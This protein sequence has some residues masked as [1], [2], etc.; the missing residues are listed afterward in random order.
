MERGREVG[1]IDSQGDIR[2]IA[3]SPDGR[4][5]AA[6]TF[7]PTVRIWDVSTRQL[8]Q[9]LVAE[10]YVTYLGFGP[11]GRRLITA[12][13]S[14]VDLW[15]TVTG[16]RL[17]RLGD[18]DL[19]KD[20]LHDIAFSPDGR[21][22]ATADGRAKTSR[23]W[24]APELSKAGPVAGDPGGWRPLFNGRDLSGWKVYPSGTGQWNVK[25]GILVGSGP[26]SSLFS[27]GGNFQDFHLRAEVRVADGDISGIVF[28]APF[29]SGDIKGY[30]ARINGNGPDPQRTGS[31]YDLSPFKEDMVA[32][33]AWFV[34]EVIAEGSHIVIKVDGKTTADYVDK[35]RRYTAGRIALQH[36]S[37]SVV[38]FRKVEVKER[39]AAETTLSPPA[40]PAE[41]RVPVERNSAEQDLAS[42]GLP[43]LYVPKEDW[44]TLFNGRDTSGWVEDTRR[45][46][47]WDVENGALVGRA[48]TG[49]PGLSY[50][51]SRRDYTD[52]SLRFEF[53]VPQYTNSGFVL[54][55]VPG[56]EPYHVEVSLK[57]YPDGR[58]PSGSLGW[59]PLTFSY[60][61]PVPVLNPSGTWNRMEVEMRGD[62]LSVSING[63]RAT[64]W[65]L[66]KFAA[67]P[68]GLPGLKHRSGRIGFQSVTGVASF[69]N[70]EIRDLQAV[71]GP[72]DSTVR[73]AP[74]GSPRT[75]LGRGVALPKSLKNAIG[76]EL[77]HIPA[78]AF[79]MGSNEEEDSKP[80]HRVRIT[81]PFYLASHEVTQGQFARLFGKN[82]SQFQSNDRLPVES[83]TWLDSIR[84]CNLLSRADRLAPYYEIAGDVVSMKGGPG[85]RL[86]T[87]AEWEY[88]CGEGKASLFCFGD[89]YPELDRYGWHSGNSSLVTHPVGQKLPNA[90]GLYDMHGN[91]W[92]W[93]WD[94]Y[95]EKFFRRT[96]MDDPSWPGPGD[97]HVVRGGSY[98]AG[99]SSLRTANRSAGS[100]RNHPNPYLVGFRVARDGGSTT[101]DSGSP[102]AGAGRQGTPT[103]PAPDVASMGY[104][105]LIALAERTLK[106]EHPDRAIKVLDGCPPD[107]RSWEWAY[108]RRLASAPAGQAKGPLTLKHRGEDRDDGLPYHPKGVWGL[109]FSPDGKVLASNG[110]LVVSLWNAANGRQLAALRGRTR[111]GF[112]VAFSPDGSAVAA[113]SEDGVLKVWDN[114]S[115]HLT[116]VIEPK[117]GPVDG[118]AFSADGARLYTSGTDGTIRVWNAA[119]AAPIAS[120]RG[121][122][123]FIQC[124]SL[125]RDGRLLATGGLHDKTVKVWDA[126]TGQLVSS[127]QNDD[128]I[129]DVA[130][131]PDGGLV[132]AAAWNGT[133]KVIDTSTGLELRAIRGLKGRVWAVAFS[134]D[135]L[136]IASGS[137][138]EPGVVLWDRGSGERIFQLKTST[139]VSDVVFSLD[140]RRLAATGSDGVIQ[141]WDASPA[142]EASPKPAGSAR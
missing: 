50:L 114:S 135:G 37:G 80:I 3:L 56:E 68:T 138:D 34:L 111:W 28:R 59:A 18:H 66:R 131:S 22:I 74:E 132:A 49:G 102:A 53:Q 96:A 89:G 103:E 38:E 134:L 82:P 101:G 54:R 45:G 92:E 36:Q 14:G 113:A 121:H 105:A 72:T 70:I 107:R 75:E 117:N 140:G 1:S 62:N 127:F 51:L 4:R 118:V 55:A 63:H 12:K 81:R 85:Y 130:F 19:R 52:F 29:G 77:M 20:G 13:D 24:H 42:G 104:A 93:C 133:I 2:N 124:L 69:R 5:V 25:G 23:I 136:R 6:A 137:A 58:D 76:M 79:E 128:R 126:G 78:G 120:I 30:E 17:L 125:S 88:A 16:R 47:T 10:D 27:E 100:P 115:G 26:L 108:L 97:V 116:G 32:S 123:G 48:P 91:V 94:V 86:P 129:Q 44:I 65:D 71:R 61:S 64:H 141:L 112:N 31:L 106:E 39:M 57:N 11:D 43:S 95:D 67:Q 142:P 41:G 60:P 109:A 87:E 8:V 90:L 7:S 110:G 46:C 84:F 21:R 83:V 9:T 73:A 139:G 99:P 122:S 35:E 119:T 98:A 33:H 40:P 15:D